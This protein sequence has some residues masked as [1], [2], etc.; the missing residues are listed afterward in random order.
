MLMPMLDAV[1]KPLDAEDR[2]LAELRRETL[3]DALDKTL[4]GEKGAQSELHRR[5]V[6]VG[7][8]RLA[9]QTINKWCRGKAPMTAMTLRGVLT[10]LGLP[11]TWRKGD[12]LPHGWALPATTS[13]MH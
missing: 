9:L 2:R 11:P 13:R 12:P 5:L 1:A 8:R 6:D 4:G 3:V 7:E 10:V